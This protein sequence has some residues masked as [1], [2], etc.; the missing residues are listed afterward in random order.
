MSRRRSSWCSPL[1]NDTQWHTHTHV[2]YDLTRKVRPIGC[3]LLSPLLGGLPY[4]SLSWNLYRMHPHRP[5]I[6]S[7]D[8]F[9]SWFYLSWRHCTLLKPSLRL[10]SCDLFICIER[11]N[12]YTIRQSTWDLLYAICFLLTNS[13]RIQCPRESTTNSLLFD[14]LVPWMALDHLLA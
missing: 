9:F 11:A 5:Y 4:L 10:E 8:G 6:E 13:H 2:D 14:H 7:T 3:K 1:S 12:R